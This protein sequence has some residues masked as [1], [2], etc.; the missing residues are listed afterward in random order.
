MLYV[1]ITLFSVP[2]EKDFVVDGKL[3]FEK[4]NDKS[5]IELQI[6]VN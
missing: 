6:Q 5:H 2:T 1:D 4:E 3:L